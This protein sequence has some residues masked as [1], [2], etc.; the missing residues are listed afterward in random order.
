MKLSARRTVAIA[1]AALV[2]GVVIKL[3]LPSGP[4]LKSFTFLGCSGDWM[5]ETLE[6]QVWRAQTPAS[7]TFLVKHP[8]ICGHTSG[9]NAQV[10]VMNERSINFSYELSNDR[11][12]SG[13]VPV[14]SCEYW[15]AFEMKESPK[16]IDSV[17]VNGQKARLMS[18]LRG[19]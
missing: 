4:Q 2:V 9:S 8:A 14:C 17:S 18:G 19:G 16:G 10:V 11:G 5:E 7:T 1:L 3:I 6:P 12:D 15:A 13:A